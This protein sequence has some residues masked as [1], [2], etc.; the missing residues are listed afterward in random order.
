M[1]GRRARYKL[2]EKEDIREKEKKRRQKDETK[3]EKKMK[4]GEKGT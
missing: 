3:I 4:G 2:K 1:L